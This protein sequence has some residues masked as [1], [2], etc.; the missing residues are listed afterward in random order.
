MSEERRRE[1]RE[2][3]KDRRAR[4]SPSDVGLPATARRRVRGLRREEVATLAGIGV[5]WYTSLE[6]GDAQGVSE[7]TLHAV[8]VALRLSESERDYL[9]DLAVRAEASDAAEAPKP[10]VIDAMNASVF[11]AYIITAVWDV[12]ACNDAFRRVW[13]V[14][15]GELPFNAIER[16]FIVP[17]ARAMHGPHFASNIAP[18]IGMFRSGIGRRPSSLRLRALRDRLVADRTIREIWDAYDIRSPL[19]SNS[20]TIASPVGPFTYETLTLT[21]PGALH[22]IVVQVPDQGSRERLAAYQ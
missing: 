17:A 12:I 16:L 19:L 20:C 18:V 22:G 10:L 9:L 3:L 4:V 14:A 15:P 7:A 2:F 5:S 11:P 13:A 21:L 8:A 1:L 6:N